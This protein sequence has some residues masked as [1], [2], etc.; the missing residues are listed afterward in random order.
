MLSRPADL[1]KSLRTL[2]QPN[3]F[4][5]QNPLP[6]PSEN[7]THPVSASRDAVSAHG[8]WWRERRAQILAA[9]LCFAFSIAFILNIHPIG[10]GLWFWYAVLWR[11][12]QRLYA[13]MHLPLQPLYVL[14]TAWSQW[15]LGKGWLAGKVLAAAQAAVYCL[16]LFLVAGYGKWADS[17]KALSIA[18]AFGLSLTSF[19]SRFDDYHVTGYIFEVWSVYLLLRLLRDRDAG[20]EI[21]VATA[22]GVCS[23]LSICNRL[24]DGGALFGACAIILPFCVR[25]RK[26]LALATFCCLAPLTLLS[27]ILLTGDSVR[28]WAVNSIF[29]AAAI[30]G[31]T[32]HVLRSPLLYPRRLL[33]ELR[34]NVALHNPIA[35][36]LGIAAGASLMA[37]F[38]LDRHG[39]WTRRSWLVWF[40]GS[41][42]IVA[43]SWHVRR[44]LE[45]GE[46]L[47]DV[48]MFATPL[49]FVLSIWL[50]MRLAL[51]VFRRG[52]RTS[53]P[54]LLLLL[55]PVLQIP[56]TTLSSRG[57]PSVLEVF[58]QMAVLF[59]LLPVA[60]PGHVWGRAAKGAY[61]GLAAWLIVST[62]MTKTR[63]PYYWHHFIDGPMFV[64]R[65]WYSHPQY[66]P[67][68][69]Q[70]DQ[71]AIVKSLCDE[72][73]R[74]GPPQELLS[75]TNPYPNYFCNV[76]PWHG[77]VQT[78][79]DT[80]S[81]QTIDNLMSELTSGPP[82][83]VIYQRAPDSIK[84]HEEVFNAS[85]PIPHRALDELIVGR[86][87]SGQWQLAYWE[88]YNGADWMVLRT[89]P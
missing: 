31:G 67:M 48:T 49:V 69:I 33:Q 24:N 56:G 74:D 70:R 35:Y 30:K 73:W 27:V 18:A 44:Y 83:W 85:K 42:L 11:G 62:G 87:T 41:G 28:A 72:I 14:L 2:W 37:R 89:R 29:H 4:R 81:K 46:A 54:T 9:L 65:V 86:I 88:P 82:K 61:L 80:A 55:I 5:E 76:V 19:Y 66:G 32:D 13:D 10:D 17:H 78:W 71:L 77:Y 63:H 45:L 34:H 51:M 15:L 50:T 53:D 75:I 57:G 22:L 60:L 23:G 39:R 7:I 25:R 59:L 16:G 64:G 43:A 36:V 68:Y 3:H 52:S 6:T 21:W 38:G 58:P 8:G 40:A 1:R 12:G 79:Y 20:H 84:A 26:V 47:N